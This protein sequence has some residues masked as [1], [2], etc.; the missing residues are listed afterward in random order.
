VR[1][2]DDELV[3]IFRLLKDLVELDC[4]LILTRCFGVELAV[5]IEGDQV[6]R[7]E[8]QPYC[9][10]LAQLIQFEARGEEFP[11]IVRAMFM[12]TCS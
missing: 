9:F 5:G 4:N 2:G 12:V 10:D 11:V 7:A 8:R 3:S 1:E 6:D